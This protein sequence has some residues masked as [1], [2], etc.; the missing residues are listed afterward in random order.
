MTGKAAIGETAAGAGNRGRH[1]FP[2][3]W[4]GLMMPA[5]HA[6]FNL[7]RWIILGFILIFLLTAI[8]ALYEALNFQG[9]VMEL[10]NGDHD[11]ASR[12]L[13]VLYDTLEDPDAYPE[14]Q[15]LPY[16]SIAVKLDRLSKVQR[17]LSD[18]KLPEEFTT[19]E[20]DAI[21]P[22]QGEP[23]RRDP[24]Q[25]DDPAALVVG[26]AKGVIDDGVN[27]PAPAIRQPPAEGESA[28][29]AD[30][31]DANAR[32]Q[33]ASQ[34]LARS[35]ADLEQT[36]ET[37]TPG[38]KLVSDLENARKHIGTLRRFSGSVET[39]AEMREDPA[40]PGTALAADEQ[41]AAGL[42]EDRFELEMLTGRLE[43]GF[44]EIRRGVPTSPGVE[45]LVAQVDGLKDELAQLE[46]FYVSEDLHIEE[47]PPA[48]EKGAI[49]IDMVVDAIDHRIGAI[50]TTLL[51]I[52][53]SFIAAAQLADLINQARGVSDDIQEM[54]AEDISYEPTPEEP[55]VKGTAA[56]AA[57][58][59]ARGELSESIQQLEDQLG[60]RTRVVA[61]ADRL[62]ELEEE[63]DEGRRARADAILKAFDSV[64]RFESTLKPFAG[65]SETPLLSVASGVGFDPQRIATLSHETLALLFVF[66]VGAIGSVIYITKDSIQ[67][68]LEGNWLTDPPKRS[69]TWHLFRPVFG[70]IVALA[71]F[72]LFKAGQLALGNGG[73]VDGSQA[74]NLPV[75]SV[76]ALFAGL[77]SWQALEAIETRGAIW[78]R[79]QRRQ[80]LWATGLERKLENE[81]RT[82]EE[83]ASS[84]GR[85]VDQVF[86]WLA[87]RDRVS[88]E[89]QDRIADW[90]DVPYNQL[91]RGE[92]PGLKPLWLRIGAGDEGGQPREA[93]ESKLVGPTFPEGERDKWLAEASPEPVPPRFQDGILLAMDLSMSEVFTDMR[94]APHSD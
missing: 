52:D 49:D 61:V 94:P 12:V 32:W 9:R 25:G 90:L 19:T 34:K 45:L 43:A 4:A 11:R 66:V 82:R 33:S 1:P 50:E 39:E 17:S 14:D 84:I 42:R 51:D 18:F 73:A 10:T 59:A 64:G 21:E 20:P 13:G 62:A 93:F 72:L 67:T 26:A 48:N 58:D 22:E 69:L 44:A 53:G 56:L 89:M 27:G 87:F 76:I 77:L 5:Y 55:P 54:P 75:L 92:R 46:R 40:A 71:A 35:V 28:R 38:L 68:A 80:P 74:F 79:S 16:A 15:V 41:D 60:R 3:V 24:E 37:G 36:L 65:L 31:V 78:F 30:P 29:A 81:A 70:V 91:F 8:L 83:L 85:S 7:L 88:P 57:F 63:D 86:R 23:E 47:P 6:T 2:G